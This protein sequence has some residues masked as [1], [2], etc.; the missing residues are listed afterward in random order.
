M[1]T[2]TYSKEGKVLCGL[3]DRQMREAGIPII[4]VS[5]SELNATVKV[6]YEDNAT[7]EH[8]AAG[9]A[10]M[11]AHVPVDPIQQVRKGAEQEVQAVSAWAAWSTT[12][13][14]NWYQQN[15]RD[16]FNA[17]VTLAAMKAVVGT[18]IQVQWAVIWMVIALRNQTWP[19]LQE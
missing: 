2:A 10:L 5:W 3:L 15:V 4:G 8:L 17:A 1:Q 6:D 13:A 11:A 12:Q 19:G 7:P 14:D 9:A 18:V 16:P